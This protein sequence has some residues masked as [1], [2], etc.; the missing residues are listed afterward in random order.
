MCGPQH[1]QLASIATGAT[2]SKH[3][4]TALR[5]I[6][7]VVTDKSEPQANIILDS[8]ST[9]VRTAKEIANKMKTQ[10]ADQGKLVFDPLCE[11]LKDQVDS[12]TMRTIAKKWGVNRYVNPEVG[13]AMV[14]VLAPKYAKQKNKET[15]HET[16]NFHWAG[17]IL[18][19]EIG[20]S[21][22]TI[23]NT[24]T[25]EDRSQMNNDWFFGVYPRGDAVTSENEMQTF[26]GTMVNDDSGSKYS[27]TLRIK[28]YSNHNTENI[29]ANVD[30][31][32]KKEKMELRNMFASSSKKKESEESE[33]TKDGDSGK[34]SKYDLEIV[35]ELIGKNMEK[36]LPEH[37]IRRTWQ[38][39][40][41]EDVY[42][43][44]LVTKQMQTLRSPEHSIREKWVAAKM[45]DVYDQIVKK[46]LIIKMEHKDEGEKKEEK[47]K[48]DA[49]FKAVSQ[50][51]LRQK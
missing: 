9:N 25:G 16:W 18:S 10:T 7:G 24:A 36:Y 46:T 50:Q 21:Y 44:I 49:R 33:E 3:L 35:S 34:T 47:E 37:V 32:E 28:Q 23:E 20:G 5:Q 27:M 26:H 22:V 39:R 19:E 14:N 8:D 1:Q 40:K 41:M 30:A 42:D 38:L 45:E 4:Y 12:K 43:Q 6:F 13:E 29:C 48:D 11:E 17:V 15:G 31:E 51:M 2:G